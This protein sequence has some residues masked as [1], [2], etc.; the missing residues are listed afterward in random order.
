MLSFCEEDDLSDAPIDRTTLLF[1]L[2]CNRPREKRLLCG[3]PFYNL[4]LPPGAIDGL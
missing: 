2:P 1:L 4:T 3:Y